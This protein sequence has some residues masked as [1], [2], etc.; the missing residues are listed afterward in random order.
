MHARAHTHTQ[1]TQTFSPKRQRRGKKNNKETG[2]LT[3]KWKEG[4]DSEAG[5]TRRL[6]DGK[7]RAERD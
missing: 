6:A 7:M 5:R 3:D 1:H 2:L 4:R